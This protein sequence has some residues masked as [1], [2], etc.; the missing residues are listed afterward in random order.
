VSAVERLVDALEALPGILA[1][2]ACAGYNSDPTGDGE[3]RW[4]IGF[5]LRL[6]HHGAPDAEAWRS[7][8]FLCET[9]EQLLIGGRDVEVAIGAGRREG[10]NQPSVF[11]SIDGRPTPSNRARW[12]AGSPT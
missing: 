4:E 8:A 2:R 6:D 10:D 9:V 11:F 12:P 7:L 1:C 3:Q 5:T